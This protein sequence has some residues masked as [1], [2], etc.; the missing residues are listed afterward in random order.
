MRPTVPQEQINRIVY[1][2]HHDPFQVL[3]A[4]LV[5]INGAPAIAIRAFLPFAQKA[6]VVSDG[7]GKV[8]SFERVEGTD[9]FE[10]Q[11]PERTEIFPY[12]IC[13][14]DKDGFSRQFKDPYS[15]LPVLGDLDLLLFNEGNHYR[16]YEKL[17]AQ[18]MT[19]QGVQGTCFSVWA[20]NA[21]RVSIVGDF[22]GWDGRRHPMRQ[23]GSSG[24]W[25]L[26]MPDLG[27]GAVYKFEIKAKSD[28]IL[29][30]TDPQGFWAEMRPKTAS[31]V[32]DISQYEWQDA[33]WLAEREGKNPLLQPMSIYEAH[34]GSWMRVPE[35]NTYVTYNDL[36]GPM[37]KFLKEEGY[38]HVELLPITEHPLD[39]S[40]GYQ[41]TG[42]FSPTSRFGTPDEFMAFVD[43]MHRNG[44][45][46]IMDW[47][48]AHFPKNDYGLVNFDGSALYEYADNRLGEH[49][50]W[51]TKVFNWG[52]NEVREFLINSAL[53]WIDKYHIDGLRVDAVA[54]MLYRDYARTDWLPERARRAGEPGCDRVP[55]ADER[56]HRDRVSRR[57]DVRGRIDLLPR[58]QPAGVSWRA[59]LHLQVEHGVD[60][61]HARVH[62]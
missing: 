37:V 55:E 16:T 29:Q 21:A 24:I 10:A 38:T 17:G 20:P 7:Q 9:F 58:G 14:E 52:R 12:E 50:E 28:A 22:N 49:L 41:V 62:H 56:A 8:G 23:R 42:Y 35:T 1:A 43:T 26:F 25:E 47:V 46:V 36:A 34:L 48:P 45:G 11:F 33:G 51:G 61:R 6:W 60:A 32:W 53:F 15:F 30:K 59:G 27:Q 3:G 39:A 2:Y 13:T 54:S 5:D 57:G 44:I 4:H 18:V 19:H 40:W 31:I